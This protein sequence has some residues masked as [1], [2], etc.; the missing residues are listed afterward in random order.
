MP[1]KKKDKPA[2][3]PRSEDVKVFC[4]NC[5]TPLR[6]KN[7]VCVD[8][9]EGRRHI[10]FQ[11]LFETVDRIEAKL[12]T[13]SEKPGTHHCPSCGRTYFGKDGGIEDAE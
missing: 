10:D 4:A 13:L 12:D 1:K 3:D 5:A 9:S 6:G 2:P 7:V 11:Q 8:C